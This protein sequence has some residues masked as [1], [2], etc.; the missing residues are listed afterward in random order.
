M[1]IVSTAVAARTGDTE[2]SINNKNAADQVRFHF[3]TQSS[4]IF[5]LRPMQ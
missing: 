1:R 3:M 5:L 2:H 4:F